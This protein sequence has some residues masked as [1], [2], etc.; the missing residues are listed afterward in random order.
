MNSQNDFY[1]LCFEILKAFQQ[2]PKIVSVLK[3][4]QDGLEYERNFP[5][6]LESFFI[7]KT[8]LFH[9]LEKFALETS[10]M[11]LKMKKEAWL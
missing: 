4:I 11:P 10:L 3:D 6:A 2:V 9:I 1:N 8:K 7:Q 5:Q